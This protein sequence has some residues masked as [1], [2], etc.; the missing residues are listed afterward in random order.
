M[1]HNSNMLSNSETRGICNSDHNSRSTRNGSG[2]GNHDST[3]NGAQQVRNH[4]EKAAKPK[5][6]EYLGSG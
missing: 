3:S 2:T 5:V 6:R 1:K 4:D